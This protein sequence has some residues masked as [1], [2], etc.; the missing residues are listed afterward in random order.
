[1]VSDGYPTEHYHWDDNV[2]Q[3]TLIPSDRQFITLYLS[4][5]STSLFSVDYGLST[6]SSQYKTC[7]PV[8][9][10][11]GS[12]P[13]VLASFGAELQSLM[14]T[15]AGAGAS[16]SATAS[17]SA[18]ADA[19]AKSPFLKPP[20]ASGSGSGGGG[21]LSK[22]MS[23]LF[24]DSKPAASGA[25]KPSAESQLQVEEDD[26]ASVAAANANAN[27]ASVEASAAP[28][29]SADTAA[30]A[31]AL[32]PTHVPLTITFNCQSNGTSVITLSIP[33]Y[34]PINASSIREAVSSPSGDATTDQS[35]VGGSGSGGGGALARVKSSASKF[36]KGLAKSVTGWFKSLAVGRG[37][38]S[39]QET[40]LA[41][42]AAAAAAKGPLH[43]V[44]HLTIT[45][46]K[47]CA[48]KAAGGG[49]SDDDG[50]NADSEQ[51]AIPGFSVGF[52]SASHEIIHN[53]LP[54]PQYVSER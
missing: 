50:D 14:P 34:R 27:V 23:R 7:N 30:W 47:E 36:L 53:G 12:S 40:R 22:I 6:V 15:I 24:G 26:A 42:A 16:A 32:V 18:A 46:R 20:K 28:I 11:K 13:G 44:H 25:A 8:L 31:A 37:W 19:M 35:A 33:L 48:L 4:L 5:N 21:M 10:G 49:G 41:A 51:V 29:P 2:H 9:S 17:S 38:M 54:T 3:T 39:E 1:M 43:P 52:T 45:F